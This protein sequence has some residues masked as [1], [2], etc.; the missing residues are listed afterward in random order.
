MDIGV[1]TENSHGGLDIGR[2]DDNF[3]NTPPSSLSR[4]HTP[5]GAP[6]QRPETTRYR[7]RGS[8]RSIALTPSCP[9][10]RLWGPG[11][12]FLLQILF[13]VVTEI[14]AV[15]TPT[16]VSEETDLS[17]PCLVA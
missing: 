11:Y 1:A 5:A 6:P 7:G 15:A 13:H 2:K 14:A 12:P 3:Y 10:E 8:L 9:G 4:Y 16:V 17:S